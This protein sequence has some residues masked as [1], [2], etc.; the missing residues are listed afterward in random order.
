MAVRA[1]AALP[2]PLRR[3]IWSARRAVG[4][5]RRRRLEARGDFTQSR[6]AL[7]GMDSRL[8]AI[9]DKDQGFFVE[10]GANDGY[11][12]SNTYSLERIRGWRGVLVEPVPDLHRE[13][14]RERPGARVFNCALVAA[15]YPGHEVTL[16]YGGLMTVV[17]GSRGSD[18]ADREWVAAAHAVAQ[19]EPEHEFSVPARTLSSLLDEVGAPE[20]D[21]LSLDVEGYEPQVLR[22]LDLERHAPRYVL[23]EIRDLGS[24]RA[25]V[26]AVLGKRYAEIEQLSPYD[27]LYARTDVE[28]PRPSA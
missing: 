11:Q 21:L 18:L 27:V 12:Q 2:A 20:I 1:I 19:E 17:G 16:R 8:E 13:A 7:Y 3:R 23:V 10:A 6:P 14:V 25:G 26:E 9:L 22:G 24:D 28:P 4:R 5:V 15:D